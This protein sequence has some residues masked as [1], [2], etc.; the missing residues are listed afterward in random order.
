M[1]IFWMLGQLPLVAVHLGA[2]RVLHILH[3]IL[4]WCEV[5]NKFMIPFLSLGG[6]KP[7][8]WH[9]CDLKSEQWSWREKTTYH[10]VSVHP[11]LAK[12]LEWICICIE[13]TP[14]LMWHNMIG[15]SQCFLAVRE[16]KA[17]GSA[18]K[19]PLHMVAF[20]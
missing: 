2:L 17:P 12:S 11:N 13:I 20:L 15:I 10:E 9:I 7:E 14:E 5:V 18:L 6:E 16:L 8:G 19:V 4:K 3:I 1:W